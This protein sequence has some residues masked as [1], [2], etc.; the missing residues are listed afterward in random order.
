MNWFSSSTIYIPGIDPQVIRL[1]SRYLFRHSPLPS[2]E[3]DTC[4]PGTKAA[5]RWFA[6]AHWLARVDQPKGETLGC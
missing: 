5:E 4:N 1:G 3:S 6:E 2:L